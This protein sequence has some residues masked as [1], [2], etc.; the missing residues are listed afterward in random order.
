M[1]LENESKFGV[2][3]LTEAINEL[4]VT[5]TL[6]RESGLFLPEYLTTTYVDIESKN[7]ELTL[8]KSQP[9]G[10]P[11]NPV[12]EKRGDLKTFKTVHLPKDE[13]VLADDVQNVRKFGSG[14]ADTVESKVNDKLAAMKSD[15]EYTREHMQLGAIQGKVIDADGSIIY[16]F[17]KEFGITRKAFTIGLGT[18]TT[19]VNGKLDEVIRYISRNL[20]GDM[21]QGFVMFASPEFMAALTGH[22]KIMELYARFE[23]TSAQYRDGSTALTFRHKNIDFIT[24]DYLFGSDVDIKPG[25]AHIVP[26]GTRKTMKEYFAPGDMNATVNT[27]AKPYYA[28]REKLPN[29]KG[30]SLHAQSNPLSVLLKP[31]AAA[32][33]KV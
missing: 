28:I 18:A 15:L 1:P 2:V 5:P 33:L 20:G 16:D 3:P 11:G 30:W 12:R 13:L 29:D 4:P 9:R 19:D 17:N 6:I 21:A 27:I 26:K 22:A 32:T 8:V 23:N 24:Y 31:L 10:N 25:E 14:Q 7:N